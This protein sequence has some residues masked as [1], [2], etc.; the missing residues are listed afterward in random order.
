MSEMC[1]AQVGLGEYGWKATSA[2]ID[3]QQQVMALHEILQI[4]MRPEVSR[5]WQSARAWCV[6]KHFAKSGKV[7]PMGH[8]H[9]WPCFQEEFTTLLWRFLRP[10]F[11]DG[12]FEPLENGVQLRPILEDGQRECTSLRRRV[13]GSVCDSLSRIG[14]AKELREHIRTSL[15][16]SSRE[17]FF[18]MGRSTPFEKRQHLQPSACSSPRSMNSYVYEAMVSC[19]VWKDG[20]RK[21]N[22]RLEVGIK[23]G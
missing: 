1:R 2:R 20:E 3:E 23:K 7:R 16:I 8:G 21:E 19:F 9:V 4:D 10:A 6:L 11:V 15:P 13:K 22:W 17:S 5:R 12:A 14:G 18:G